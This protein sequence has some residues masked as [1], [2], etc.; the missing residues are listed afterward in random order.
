M[1]QASI[2]RSAPDQP[3]YDKKHNS[4]TSG[5]YLRLLS[6]RQKRGVRGSPV[7][8]GFPAVIV[9]GSARLCSTALFITRNYWSRKRPM[10]DQRALKLI[11]VMFAALTL[12]VIST[13]AVVVAGHASGFSGEYSELAGSRD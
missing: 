5:N 3:S 9:V 10:A 4:G 7:T 6:G 2:N 8:Q 1:V 12:M 11:G 13:A